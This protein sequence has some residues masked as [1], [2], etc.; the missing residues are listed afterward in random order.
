MNVASSLCTSRRSKLVL[1]IDKKELQCILS[2]LFTKVSC[3]SCLSVF[4][5]FWHLKPQLTKISG[6]V[7]GI[8]CNLFF[9]CHC[10]NKREFQGWLQES[11]EEQTCFEFRFYFCKTKTATSCFISYNFTISKVMQNWSVAQEALLYFIQLCRKV[12][13]SSCSLKDATGSSAS[14]MCLTDYI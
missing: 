11:P 1:T 14:H 13:A 10:G 3:K 8:F 7:S 12:Y 6:L 4:V 9:V 5:L 2:F